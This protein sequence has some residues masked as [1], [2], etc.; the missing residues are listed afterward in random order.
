MC[1]EPKDGVQHAA[2]LPAT[3]PSRMCSICLPDAHTAIPLV[4]GYLVPGRARGYLGLGAPFGRRDLELLRERDIDV[5]KVEIAVRSGRSGG[6]HWWVGGRPV[7][8]SMGKRSSSRDMTQATQDYI[9]T[10]QV[11]NWSSKTRRRR[12]VG[13]SGIGQFVN[14]YRWT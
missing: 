11:D 8:Q 12:G 2:N 6:S 4:A 9:N 1:L 14:G 5:V 3:R 7:Q 10:V 13:E